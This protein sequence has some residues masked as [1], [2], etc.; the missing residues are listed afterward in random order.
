MVLLLNISDHNCLLKKLIGQSFETSLNFGTVMAASAQP[1]KGKVLVLDSHPSQ[2]QFSVG[3]GSSSQE[4]NLMV[5]QVLRGSNFREKGRGRFPYNSGQ[6]FNVPNSSSGIFGTPKPYQYSC[7]GHPIE[8]PTCQIYNKEV[9][10]QQTVFKGLWGYVSRM[11][12]IPNNP[13]DD[14]HVEL[15]AAWNMNNSKIITWINN[16]VDLTIGMQLAK[17]STS[18]DVWDHLAKLYTKANFAKRYQLEMEIRAIQQGDKS[19]QVFYNELTDLWDQLAL[20]EPEELGIVK[21]YCQYREE[22]L[23]QSLMPFRDEFETL[24]S[25]ILHRTPL[26]S[27]DSVLNE[28]QAEEVCVQSHRLSSSLSNTSA[29]VAAISCRVAMDKCSYCKGKGYWKL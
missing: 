20:T 10:L 4:Y 18:K 26:P 14:K 23:V 6:R 29:L 24:C 19:I 8:I 7:P 27:V 16:Y 28:L 9:M 15:F 25:S 17:F 5:D 22:R 2:S 1:D 12:Y 3:S 13:K 11:I 21:L